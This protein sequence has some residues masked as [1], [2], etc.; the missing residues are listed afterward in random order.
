M[1][2]G[3]LCPVIGKQALRDVLEETAFKS[4][5]YK[6]QVVSGVYNVPQFGVSGGGYYGFNFFKTTTGA[7]KVVM[8][9][10]DA[11]DNSDIQIGDLTNNLK[12]ENLT[13]L[14]PHTAAYDILAHPCVQQ[15][16]LGGGQF[17]YHVF[18]SARK[19]ADNKMYI[20]S[21]RMNSNLEITST[22]IP[23]QLGGADWNGMCL[24]V[25][26]MIH[27][28]GIGVYGYT[29]GGQSFGTNAYQLCAVYADTAGWQADPPVFTKQTR[30][31]L[32]LGPEGKNTIAPGMTHGL[33]VIPKAGDGTSLL[34][35]YNGFE[36]SM[37]TR[38]ILFIPVYNWDSDIGIAGISRSAIVVGDY[39]MHLGAPECWG[40]YTGGIGKLSLYPD[41][42]LRYFF[43]SY[44]VGIQ[45]MEISPDFMY[46]HNHEEIYFNPWANEAI[47]VGATT[48][49]FYGF[50]RKTLYFTS[51]TSGDL[52]VE[53]SPR[54]AKDDWYSLV[55]YSAVTSKIV[56]ITES[57]PLMR[58]K[59]SAAATV[60][61]T[62]LVEPNK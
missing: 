13:T 42:I 41:G 30:P 12:I 49:P 4:F 3:L 57:F 19:V 43:G 26:F 60:N 32:H 40:H 51:D 18:F 27:T 33:Q 2:G 17:A 25:I 29:E 39:D 14:I 22:H 59:F 45:A 7:N 23:L 44:G 37:P 31:I 36:G 1:N 61:A 50:G 20:C 55:T 28:R 58:L 35:H 9:V 48:Y 10:E 54:G 16:D 52:T 56:Q 38:Y 46:P 21:A 5:P 8:G 34:V 15:I 62:V 6:Q 47:S 11:D 53:F 24:D